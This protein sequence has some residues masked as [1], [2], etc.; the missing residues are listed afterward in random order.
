MPL[1]EQQQYDRADREVL[2]IEKYF[3]DEASCENNGGIMIVDRRSMHRAFGKNKPPK[4][5]ERY[6]CASIRDYERMMRDLGM[7]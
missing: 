1:T 6:G 7:H 5:H 4:R 3:Q 2:R